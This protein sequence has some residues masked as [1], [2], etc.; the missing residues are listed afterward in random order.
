MEN[1]SEKLEENFSSN[2]TLTSLDDNDG[3]DDDGGGDDGYEGDDGGGDDGGGDDG[4]G[5]DGGSGND[6]GGRLKNYNE[7]LEEK[8]VGTTTTPQCRRPF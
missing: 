5:D 4:G 1:V 8:I 7:K 6:D 3:G 2:I